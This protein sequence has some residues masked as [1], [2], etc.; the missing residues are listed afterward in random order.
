MKRRP[1]FITCLFSFFLFLNFS[2]ASA[3]LDVKYG[4]LAGVN[5]ATLSG[6]TYNDLGFRLGCV[7]GLFANIAHSEAMSFHVGLNYSQE[8]ARNSD[9][10]FSSFSTVIYDQKIKYDYITIPL[11]IRYQLCNSFFLLGGPRF[12][13]NINAQEVRDIKSG[14]PSLTD[15]S[16]G[17]RDL[18]DRLNPFYPGLLVGG[19]YT[20][21]DRVSAHGRAYY[22]FFDN[23]KKDAGDSEG[24]Y[25]LMFQLA[26]SYLLQNNSTAGSE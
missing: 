22:G 7:F 24:T 19:E 9:Y 8:G 18:N 10:D 3:Q 12:A 14:E 21:N 23:V 16:A 26:V 25:P 20:V 17:T 6:D 2:N 11:L 15:N 1:T 4:A 13:I 5:A